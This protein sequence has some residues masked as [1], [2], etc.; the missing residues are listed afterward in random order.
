MRIDKFLGNMGI[1]S[2]SNVKHIINRGRV[3]INGKTVRSAKRQIDPQVDC[4]TLDNQ[5]IDYV[6]YVYLMLNKPA[7]YLSATKDR[8][9]P[10]VM[11]LVPKQYQH[12]D[13]FPLGRLD[14]DTEGLIIM[15]NDGQLAHRLLSPKYHV[16][17]WY[18]VHCQKE[19]DD[20]QIAKLKSGVMIAGGYQTKPAQ[21]AHHA[22]DATRIKLGISEGKFHQIKQMMQA[23]GNA[24]IYLKRTNFGAITLD[25]NLAI[26]AIRPLT[27]VEIS[28]LQ[29]GSERETNNA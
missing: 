3:M 8:K 13:L 28:Q 4:V 25:K 12:Y 16:I 27:E 26:G 6:P 18:E 21:V 14:R 24:V 15:S 7:G 10:T 11:N 19:V 17:K 5:V 29:A 2:R 20:Q 9:L 23:V 1:A 22:Q